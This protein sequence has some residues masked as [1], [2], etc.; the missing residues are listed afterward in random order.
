MAKSGDT[1][2]QEQ[3]QQSV[4]NPW[5]PAQPLLQSLLSKYSGLDTGVTSGQKSALDNLMSS[6]SGI[7]NFGAEGAEAVGNLFSSDTSPQVGMLTDALKNLNTNIGGTAS[8][9]E[10]DPTKT[11]GFSDALNTITGDITKQVKGVYAGSGRAPSGAGS[12]AGSLGR[13]LMQGTAPLLQSQFNQN[14]ANQMGAAKTLFDAGTG[15]AGAIT[16]QNQIPL[17]NAL[18]AIMSGSDIGK[19]FTAPGTTQLAAANA[20]YQSPFGNLAALLGP[21]TGIASL[22]GQ[23]SGSSTGKVTQDQSLMSNLI[24]GASAGIGL[25]SFLSDERAKDDIQEVGELHDGQPV[26]SYRY[27]GDPR[28]QIGLLAQEVAEVEPEAV[29]HNPKIGMLMVDY[30]KATRRAAEIGHRQAA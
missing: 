15:T 1:Q 23:T 27:K 17:E 29:S 30:G 21:A 24:G 4:S 9:A 26:Y 13:G 10:L 5:A 22:G 18:K 16:G 6:A 14:K 19:L 7:P 12:F 11:P 20:G 8:G 2:R 25:L 28:V 3:T